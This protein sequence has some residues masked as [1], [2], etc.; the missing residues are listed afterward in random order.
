[1]RDVLENEA[2]ALEVRAQEVS[3]DEAADADQKLEAWRTRAEMFQGASPKKVVSRLLTYEPEQAA[4][5]LQL[6]DTETAN[7]LL[8][9][10]PD[11][12]WKQYSD[13]YAEALPLTED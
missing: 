11:D 1:M 13:A 3:R 4:I 9:E 5:I 10:I 7:G 2:E 6:L 8:A 12:R